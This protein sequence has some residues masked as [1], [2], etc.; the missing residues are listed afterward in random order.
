MPFCPLT[1]W[2][3]NAAAGQ[4]HV[5]LMQLS[6]DLI[7]GERFDPQSEPDLR[8][9]CLSFLFIILYRQ[10]HWRSYLTISSI[11]PRSSPGYSEGR[12]KASLHHWL[13][14]IVFFI[15]EDNSTH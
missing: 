12:V 9:T 14:D 4:F 1:T 3:E 15:L 10:V 11:I 2:P 13:L 6:L 8:R 5:L 7:S